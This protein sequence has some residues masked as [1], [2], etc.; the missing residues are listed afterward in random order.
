MIS[1]RIFILKANEILVTE[2]YKAVKKYTNDLDHK[3]PKYRQTFWKPILITPLT[4]LILTKLTIFY[5]SVVDNTRCSERRSSC[6]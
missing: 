4:L 2:S 6:R 5:P 1:F 3:R